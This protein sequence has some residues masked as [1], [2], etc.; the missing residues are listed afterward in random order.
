M[1]FANAQQVHMVLTA[2]AKPGTVYD[3]TSRCG[4]RSDLVES[5]IRLLQYTGRIVE[6]VD[7]RGHPAWV[8]CQP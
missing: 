3:V 7:R 5:A 2:L 1:K 6:T 4:I 8:R